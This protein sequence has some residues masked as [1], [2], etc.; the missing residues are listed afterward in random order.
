M[1]ECKS[2]L[3]EAIAM[4]TTIISMNIIHVITNTLLS[5]PSLLRMVHSLDIIIAI[6]GIMPLLLVA[7]I[8]LLLHSMDRII[9][10]VLDFPALLTILSHHEEPGRQKMSFTTGSTSIIDLARPH[11]QFSSGRCDY[12][13]CPPVGRNM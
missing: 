1:Q 7:P 4:D 5:L 10:V 6:F 11:L 3:M 2:R 9:I 12:V 13:H 8:S